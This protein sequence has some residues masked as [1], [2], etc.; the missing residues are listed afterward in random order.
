MQQYARFKRLH[1]DAILFFRMGDFYEMFYEDARLAS[2]ILGIALTSRSKG[3]KYVPMAGVPYHA[4][5]GYIQKLLRANHRVAICEQVQDPKEAKGL[6]DRD[7]VQI[8][9]RGTVMDESFLDGKRANYLVS[10]VTSGDRA[11]VSWVDLSTGDF[12]AHETL[13]TQ[14][15][16][17][18]SM[19]GPSEVL[20][21]EEDDK[22][23]PAW[24]RGS[25]AMV[26]RRPPWTFS[27]DEAYK[28][29]TKHFSTATLDGFGCEE[30]DL[31]V[32]AAGALIAYLNETQKVELAHIRRVVRWH[33]E[34]FMHLDQS[35]RWSLELTRTMRSGMSEGSLLGTIDRTVTAMGARMLSQWVLT[36]L[37]DVARIRERLDGVEEFFSQGILRGDVVK[38]LKTVHDV[39]RLTAKVTTGRANARDVLSLGQSLSALPALKTLLADVK[40]ETLAKL[41]DAVDPIEELEELIRKGVALDPPVTLQEGAIIREGYSPELDELRAIAGGGEKWLEDYR[42]AESRR[43]GIPSLRVAFN[44]VF[45]YY[46]EVTHTHSD[47]V[48]DNYI[49][50]QTVKNAERYITPELKEYE[51]KV[52][53]ADERAKKLEYDLFVELRTQAAG[54]VERLQATARALATLDVTSALAQVAAENRYVRPQLTEDPVIV[55]RDGRHP[56]LERMLTAEQFVPNDADLSCEKRQLMIITGPNMAGKSTYIR[57]V[58]L[59]V[60][61]AQMGSFVPAREATVGVADRIFTRVGASDEL[62]RGQSTFMVEMIEAAN[63]LN[64]ATPTSLIIL[65]EIGR[66]TSTFDGLA[67]AWAVAEHIHERVGARTLFAT[68]YHELTELALLLP[69]VVNCNIAV[70]EWKDEVIF[71]RKIVEG[72]TDK[73]YGIHV[74]RLAGIPPGVVERARVILGNLEEE[75]LDLGGKPKLAHGKEGPHPSHAKVQL[76]L[77]GPVDRALADEIE[78]LDL[79]RMTPVEALMKLKELKEKLKEGGV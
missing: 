26:T 69:R 75:E 78:K 14:V 61:M 38:A 68:H 29:L 35:T 10:V 24:L 32:S 25:E 55:I 1:P 52:L 13:S 41:R 56:V 48:P 31:G 59:I 37:R 39:E 50:K 60:L 47:K 51:S 12:V 8:V 76:S 57:Q 63:I 22:S 65:D 58:A 2:R 20:L 3:D 42:A 67:I 79:D 5:A 43:T 17:T 73:S 23:T 64:N 7:V 71:L 44:K 46:I 49:R 72:S 21:P 62:A 18:L 66:G 74:A 54:F 33:P 34:T 11:G 16:E 9:S 45:G 53:S 30:L 27:R 40:C 15:P 28:A 6:V 77:F 70:R 36:P 4:A 19:L